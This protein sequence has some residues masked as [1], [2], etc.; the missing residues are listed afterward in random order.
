[1]KRNLKIN[2]FFI[3]SFFLATQAARTSV[4]PGMII[5][6]HG[7]SS[8][9][10]STLVAA[11]QKIYPTFCIMDWDTYMRTHNK[12]SYI[13]FYQ[14]IKKESEQ[15][16]NILVDTVLYH[17]KYSTYTRLLQEQAQLIKIL[18]YCPLDTLIAHVIKRN[19]IH[20]YLEHRSISIAFK[21][22][23]SLYK[24]KRSK[25]DPIIDIIDS[26]T[27]LKALEKSQNVVEN[28]S[29]KD[30]KNQSKINK[31]LIRRFNLT[32]SHELWL[33]PKHSW[34]LIINISLDTP[35]NIALAIKK[36]IESK[37]SKSLSDSK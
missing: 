35:E 17:K 4:K 30:R 34:D 6:L 28:W 22:F 36:F 37:I 10:K 2:I 15:G 20:D 3:L 12:K 5:L 21:A 13:Q 11:L 25:K 32:K 24:E 9:G 27:M 7:T 23:A 14:K 8:A 1:M 31:K 19:Q 29:K 18:V 33:T 26:S 16:K